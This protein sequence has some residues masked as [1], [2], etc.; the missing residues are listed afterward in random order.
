MRLKVVVAV[1]S[2]LCVVNAGLYAQTLATLDPSVIT[3]ADVNALYTPAIRAQFGTSRFTSM[4]Q[5][6]ELLRALMVVVNA[7]KKGSDILV[8]N[9]EERARLRIVS[10]KQYL[11]ALMELSDDRI[12]ALAQSDVDQYKA[13]IKEVYDTSP[14]QFLTPAKATVAHILVRVDRHSALEAAKI[15]EEVVEKARSGE[16]FEA[17]VLKYSEDEKS[18]S[19]GGVL[20]EF[21]D[22]KGS[23]HPMVAAAFRLEKK[24]GFP[25]P[26]L[27]R[28]GI[29]VVKVL[30][31]S[32][33]SRAT[34]DQASPS[35]RASLIV[36]SKSFA[37][38]RWSQLLR[39]S[40]DKIV[41]NSA[42]IRKLIAE[43]ASREN[44]KLENAVKLLGTSAPPIS[45]PPK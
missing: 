40:T 29:H 8:L 6:T 36:Q 24:R 10:S 25:D 11:D 18:S 1:F 27:S 23:D 28:S 21:A 39:D 26:I 31:E 16:N 9:E 12:D 34:L 7:S 43:P 20:G 33:A 30:S 38:Q 32:P 44:E 19:S 4:E 35:I 22:I 5:A 3:V 42:E 37:R 15:A 45:A 41:F 14:T 13:R 2:A 17:L